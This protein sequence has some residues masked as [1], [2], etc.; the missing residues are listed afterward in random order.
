MNENTDETEHEETNEKVPPRRLKKCCANCQHYGDGDLRGPRDETVI[1]IE[2]PTCPVCGKEI[3]WNVPSCPYCGAEFEVGEGTPGYRCLRMRFPDL[4]PDL[5]TYNARL[6][7][8]KKAFKKT[9]K[10]TMV[11]RDFCE[12]FAMVLPLTPEELL[13]EKVADLKREIEADLA[14]SKTNEVKTVLEMEYQRL[15]RVRAGEE[16]YEKPVE[17][18]PVAKV[19]PSVPRN[20]IRRGE[21]FA[22]S[23]CDYTSLSREAAKKHFKRNHREAKIAPIPESPQPDRKVDGGDP[24]GGG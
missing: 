5:E 9:G 19:K 14:R 24:W 22:C 16:P 12:K 13:E 6:K 10:H 2:G 23:M 8:D 15:L 21:G 3:D 7:A 17:K 18:V 4:S 11:K 20:I 1:P